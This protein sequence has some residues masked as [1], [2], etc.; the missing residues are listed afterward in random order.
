[1]IVVSDTSAL[2]NLIQVQQL[3]I[4]AALFK[5]IVIPQEVYKELCEITTQKQLIDNQNW[6][7]VQPATNQTKITELKQNLAI[8]PIMEQL[9]T[10]GFR[11]KPTLF[12]RVLK[13]VNE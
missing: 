13:E 8:K 10:I 11:I 6:I 2:G 12:D 3:P 9:L 7:L 1:M 5:Q 4:L